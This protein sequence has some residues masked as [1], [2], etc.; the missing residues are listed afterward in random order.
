MP[1]L[2][3]QLTCRIV[4]FIWTHQCQKAFELLIQ[5]NH[6]P[7]SLTTKYGWSTILIQ[8]YTTSSDGKAVS[9]QHP[10]SYISGSF[11]GSQL[12]WTTLTEESYT[13]YMS[14]K[15]LTF[16]LADSSIALRSGHL[17]QKGFFKRK[18]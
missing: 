17:P 1:D 4:T 18:P 9:Q 13:I 12:N 5:M 8:E 14:V 7:C 11:Q 3:T 10:I 15:K 6:T 2:L 16:Y